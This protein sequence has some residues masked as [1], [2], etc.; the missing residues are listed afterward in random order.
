METLESFVN[1]IAAAANSYVQ[2]IV[3]NAELFNLWTMLE[4][5]KTSEN[6]STQGYSLVQGKT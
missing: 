3:E 2:C 1:S 6:K 4:T 5:E